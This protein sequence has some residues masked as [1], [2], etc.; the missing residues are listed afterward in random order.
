MS[1]PRTPGE[2]QAE[3]KTLWYEFSQ[4]FAVAALLRDGT[5]SSD[6]TVHN[7][8]VES[9]AIHCR[10]ICCFFFHC[11][12]GFPSLQKDDLGAAHYDSEW[13]SHHPT[14]PSI[15]IDAKKS[16]DKQ[17]AHMTARRRDLNFVPSK[18]HF[19]PVVKIEDEL[20][21]VLT[22]F[23]RH[24]PNN[25]FDPEALAGLQKFRSVTQPQTAR[26]QLPLA[27]LTAKTCAPTDVRTIG[28]PSCFHG[29]TE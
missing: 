2:L 9:F 22:T 15:L 19:W 8:L 13:E 4:F 23:L 12:K 16:C 14:A 20:R 26:E 1:L 11:D 17:V 5:Y 10:A 25:L 18:M 29:K 7:A 28:P 27:N 3:S 21:Q 24:V 6:V